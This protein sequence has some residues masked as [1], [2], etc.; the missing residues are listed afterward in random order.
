L[1]TS[2]GTIS[3]FTG[4]EGWNGKVV[5]LKT[6]EEAVKTDYE[7]NVAPDP[8]NYHYSSAPTVDPSNAVRRFQMNLPKIPPRALDE[9][10]FV[11]S[12]ESSEHGESVFLCNPCN[13]SFNTDDELSSHV[14]SNH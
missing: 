7:R 10:P 4:V 6:E 5:W 2:I 11:V 9:R 3:L 14:E 1:S 8:Y 13:E 12:Q